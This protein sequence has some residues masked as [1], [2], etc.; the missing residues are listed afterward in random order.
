MQARVAERLQISRTTVSK[1]VR[2]YRAEGAARLTDLSSKPHRSPS[3]TAK[4]TER[5]IIALRFT[6]RRGPHRIGDHLG[7]RNRRAGV[8]QVF[9][10]SAIDH[11]PRLVYSEVLTNEKKETAAG[12]WERANAFYAPRDVTVLR[13]MTDNGSCYCFAP[14]TIPWR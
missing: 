6:R 14:G 12:F 11:Y 13:V 9:L 3:Q 10:H 2:R 4:R 1:W 5:L 7:K 8:G